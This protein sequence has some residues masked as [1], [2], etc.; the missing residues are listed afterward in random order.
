M[1]RI[2][3]AGVALA[4][5]MGMTAVATAAETTT[6]DVTLKP[7]K[8]GAGAALTVKYTSKSDEDFE[9]APYQ[10]HIDFFFAKGMS[11]PYKDFPSC[12]I[13]LTAKVPAKCKPAKVGK[14]TALNDARVENLHSVPAT[15]DLY[16]GGAPGILYFPAIV[17]RPAAV[18]VYIKGV[19]K[20][21]SGPYGSKLDVPLKLPTILPDVE[22][23]F[24]NSFKIGPV[25]KT[26]KKNGKTISFINNPKTCTSAGWKFRLVTTYSNGDVSTADDTVKCTK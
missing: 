7:P 6:I 13:P 24:V 14:G 17:T 22:K 20:K 26:T 1:R 3:A 10:T 11:F 8:A 25:S 16:N 12:T 15:L 4:T 2:I 5:M 23:P 19:M 9:T 21:A 18:N